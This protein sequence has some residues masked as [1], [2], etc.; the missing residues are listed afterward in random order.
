MIWIAKRGTER[1]NH[2]IINET[3]PAPVDL[4]RSECKPTAPAASTPLSWQLMSS[5]TSTKHSLIDHDL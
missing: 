5:P 4:L 1:E 3:H 2:S